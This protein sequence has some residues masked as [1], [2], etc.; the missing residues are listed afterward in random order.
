VFSYRSSLGPVDVAF[1]DRA[2]GVGGS[3]PLDLSL[4]GRDPEARVADLRRVLAEFAGSGDAPHAS[5]RQVHGADVVEAAPDAP[6]GGSGPPA[7]D[8]LVTDRPGL[9]LVVRV[10]DCVPVLLADPGA[11]VVGAVHAGRV[12]VAAGVVGAALTAL[13]ARGAR[14]VV[15]WVGPHVCG[16]C[17]EVP[18]AMRAEVAE[19]APEAWATT[20]WGTPALDL[21]AAVRAQ[22]E[23]G[24]ASV[25]DASR[26][27]VEGEDL[28]SYRRDG[29]RAGR[30]AGLVRSR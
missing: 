2:A 5:M 7:A 8:G 21:G 16:S 17:Y 13:R 23:A 29:P 30:M 15:A 25:T 20:S 18:E 24:G 26:C 9:V 4:T 3:A 28:H 10:A 27:T 22:L 12:G 19:S 6:A 14:E 11:G 1:T